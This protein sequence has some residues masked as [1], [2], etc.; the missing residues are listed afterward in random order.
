MHARRCKIYEFSFGTKYIYIDSSQA[1][2]HYVILYTDSMK[3]EIWRDR[4][5][6]EQQTL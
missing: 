6:I 4:E 5:A 3:L 1:N 2:N